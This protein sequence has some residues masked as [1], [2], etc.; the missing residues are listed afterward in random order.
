MSHPSIQILVA[1]YKED[2]EWTKPLQN[3]IIYNKGEPLG[4]P[5]HEVFLPN[6][7][8]EGHTYYQFICD[9]YDTLM[10]Y[11][12]FVQGHPFDHSPYLIEHIERNL[13]LGWSNADFECLSY[14]QFYCNLSGCFYHPGIPL[15]DTYERI[16][17]ER[18]TEMG[19]DF[20]AGAHF[21]VSKNS[22]LKRPKS[23]YE[24]IVKI[25]EYDVNPIE[26]FVV[27]RF[28]KLI[29]THSTS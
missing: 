4:E 18:K 7:G 29:F 1:R 11:T 21:M 10:D 17:G 20:G 8:R 23:F 27:E 14:K 15:I 25:L 3:V 16:F 26:G 9:H 12:I 6:V 2:V 22:I 19:F 24:N 5:Y 28:H 13:G